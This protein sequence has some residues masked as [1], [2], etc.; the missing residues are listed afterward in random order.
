VIEALPA[1]RV[2]E[3][4]LIRRVPR[5]PGTAPRSQRYLFMTT[6]ARPPGR[7]TT[8]FGGRDEIIWSPPCLITNGIAPAASYSITRGYPSRSHVRDPLF[9]SRNASVCCPVASLTYGPSETA[10]CDNRQGTAAA[11]R[12]WDRAAAT[13]SA[14][15]H[16]PTIVTALPNSDES[17]AHNPRSASVGGHSRTLAQA[18]AL[19]ADG[20]TGVRDLV[21][22][23][24][25]GCCAV[26]S[27][28][29]QA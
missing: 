20:G 14:T 28:F 15:K 25:R 29:E 27:T 26:V 18:K 13:Q 23:V 12:A 9:A 3:L 10:N 16:T 7:T 6:K 8:A 5:V 2:P 24:L 4:I 21:G 17:S 11:G 1:A 22:V 19:I